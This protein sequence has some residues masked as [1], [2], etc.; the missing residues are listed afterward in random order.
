MQGARE[1]S[2]QLLSA[3]SMIPGPLELSKNYY[4]EL[5]FPCMIV[6]DS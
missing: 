3:F 1:A 5:A 4:V 2:L 6:I